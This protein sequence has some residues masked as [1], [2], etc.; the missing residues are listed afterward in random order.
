M[1][2]YTSFLD[3]KS[4]I[5]ISI[6]LNSIPI[7]IQAG[8][9]LFYYYYYLFFVFSP[10]RAS[11]VAYAGSKVRGLIGAVAPIRSKLYLRPT[12]TAHSNARSLT[13]ERGQGSNPQP[14]GS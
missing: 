2:R 1:E 14:H 11:P 9:L 8:F 12:T 10:F 4:I 13:N 7:S 5:K 3:L 6:L